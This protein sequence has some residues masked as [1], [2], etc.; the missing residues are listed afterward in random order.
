M[1]SNSYLK[2]FVAFIIIAGTIWLAGIGFEK[3]TFIIQ[4]EKFEAIPVAVLIT[5]LMMFFYFYLWKLWK[6]T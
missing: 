3:L 1:N 2:Y 5:A 6:M 4:N